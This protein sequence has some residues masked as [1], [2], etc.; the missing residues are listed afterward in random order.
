MKPRGYDLSDFDDVKAKAEDIY[1]AIEAE[2]MPPDEPW[3]DEM[4]ATFKSWR[5][6]GCPP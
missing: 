6:Q 2:R 3:T 1:D 5:D 4:R